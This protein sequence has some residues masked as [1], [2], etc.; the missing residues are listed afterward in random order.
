MYNGK[1]FFN[2][3]DDSTEFLDVPQWAVIAFAPMPNER[4]DKVTGTLNLYGHSEENKEWEEIIKKLK[5]C[6]IQS[7]KVEEL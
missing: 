2:I 4:I 3:V 6:Y 5:S 1:D 7:A